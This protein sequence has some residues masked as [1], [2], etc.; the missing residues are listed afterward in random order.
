M[1]GATCNI[2]EGCPEFLQYKDKKVEFVIC[3]ETLAKIH[4][5]I[6]ADWLK[7]R[8]IL[9]C[10]PC[11]SSFFVEISHP[12]RPADHLLYTPD[13]PSTVRTEYDPLPNT[14]T[15]TR[16]PTNNSQDIQTQPCLAGLEGR[17]Q[18]LRIC[19][20][21]KL[22]SHLS[23]SAPSPAQPPATW[24][25]GSAQVNSSA[26]QRWRCGDPKRNHRISGRIKWT[27]AAICCEF[28]WVRMVVK[29]VN[30]ER[31]GVDRNDPSACQHPVMSAYAPW[32]CQG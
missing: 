3:T 30:P 15:L 29:L 1:V 13:A 6:P 23:S 24:S 9:P 18:R 12:K 2:S 26:F 27:D 16:Y 5:N 8:K 25:P 31:R 20:W 19:A 32:L 10:D 28:L 17:L 22:R 11:L 4:K 21:Q 14:L 7:P